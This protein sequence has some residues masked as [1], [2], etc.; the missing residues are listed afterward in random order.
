[1]HE[2]EEQR[3]Q[4][5]GRRL[6]DKVS[7]WIEITLLGFITSLLGVIVYFYG[8]MPKRMSELVNITSQMQLEIVYLK[9]EVRD[10][11][12][13]QRVS[14]SWRERL[15]DIEKQV[16]RNT[17]Q[18]IQQDKRLDKLEEPFDLFGSKKKK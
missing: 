9:E 6:S 1:M 3:D 11:K 5:Y 12:D 14:Q 13:A 18:N 4:G 10:L 15:V 16:D 8:D 17:Q 7:R 2:H